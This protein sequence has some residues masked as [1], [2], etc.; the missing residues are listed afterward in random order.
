MYINNNATA[1][2]ASSTTGAFYGTFS[3]VSNLAAGDQLYMWIFNGTN[4]ANAT[5]WGVFYGTGTAWDVP[6]AGFPGS[7]SISLTTANATPLRGSTVLI[8]GTTDYELANI[9]ASVPEPTSISLLAGALV[10]GGVALR[11]RM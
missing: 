6:T 1:G 9:P 8:N 7:T 11:R 10:M 5:Q 3:S 2:G 4:P